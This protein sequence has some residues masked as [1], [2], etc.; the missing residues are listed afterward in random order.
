MNRQQKADVIATLKGNFEQSSA[1]FIVGFQGLTVAQLQKLRGNLRK[2]GGSLKVTKA[3]LMKRAAEG[4]QGAETLV[5]HFKNQIGIVFTSGETPAVAKVL[6]DFSKENQALT[7]IAGYLDA[8]FLDS[9]SVVRIASLPSRE[10]LLAQVCGTIKAPLAN[11]VNV[12]N[13]LVLRLLWTLKQVGDT[14]QQ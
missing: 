9:N 14:K 12:L 6:H 10:V 1:S 11:S 5:P 13:V 7:V 2:N 8:E 3:R 4:I